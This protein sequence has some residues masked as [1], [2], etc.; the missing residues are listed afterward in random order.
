MKNSISISDFNLKRVGYGQYNVTYISPATGKEYT[1]RTTDSSLIDATFNSDSPKIK[2]LNLL[3][4]IAKYS[5]THN[6]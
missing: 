5:C 6:W 1:S 4:K 3:K 2:D